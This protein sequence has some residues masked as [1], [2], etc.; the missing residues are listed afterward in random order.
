[1]KFASLRDETK[2]S[3]SEVR[4]LAQRLAQAAREIA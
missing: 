4:S 2:P 3:T 1:M